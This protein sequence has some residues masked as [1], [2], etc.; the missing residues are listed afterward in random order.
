ML[1]WLDY[2]IIY[3][4]SDNEWTSP[5]H[6]IPKKI[7]GIIIRNEKNKVVPTHVQ[8]GRRAFIHYRKL[9]AFTR[10]EHFPLPFPDQKL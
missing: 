10:E 7:G 3:P 1:K 2:G 8:F 6:V 5:I 4:I 9:D